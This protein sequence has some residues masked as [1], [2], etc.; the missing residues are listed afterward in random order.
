[1]KSIYS[2]LI[3]GF[4]ITILLSFPIAGI[5]AFNMNGNEINEQVSGEIE[6]EFDFLAATISTVDTPERL[7]VIL[8]DYSNSLSSAITL[9]Y[10]EKIYYYGTAH[11]VVSL[12]EISHLYNSEVLI[13]TATN[14]EVIYGKNVK[15]LD[16]EAYLLIQKDTLARKQSYLNSMLIVFSGIFLMGTIVFFVVADVIV[17]PITKLIKATKDVS[18]GNYGVRVSYTGD[19]EISKLNKAF[20]QMAVQLGKQEVYRQKF[21]SDVSHEFQTPLTSIQGFAK[22][23][24]DEADLPRDQLERYVDIIIYNSNRLSQLSKNMLQLTMLESE[25]AQLD[26]EEYNLLEQLTMVANSMES[27]AL[28]K[29]IEIKFNFPKKAVLVYGDKSKLEQVWTNLI[30]NAIKYTL[31]H[32]LITISV[33]KGQKLIEVAVEDTG[34]GMSKEVIS[35]IFERFYR[36]DK[37]RNIEGN[38]LGLSIVRTIVDLHGG[39]IDVQSTVDVGS[40]FTVILPAYSQRAIDRLNIKR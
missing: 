3:L 9:F 14:S 23:I 11:Q 1:M 36:E 2:K 35:H 31:D 18:N 26:L 27:N 34:L 37:S 4:L 33:K 30:S 24:K 15:I 22:I 12:N 39:K 5:V 19:D 13:A 7:Y 40:I 8:N 21:I 17:R 20:N 6:K 25:Q 28:K 16:S 38:G 10:Q 32:G 29:D